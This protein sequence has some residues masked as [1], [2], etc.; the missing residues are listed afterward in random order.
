MTILNS[1]LFEAL[2]CRKRLQFPAH[3]SS[4]S[5]TTELNAIWN[6]QFMS[7]AAACDGQ[8]YTVNY[9]SRCTGTEANLLPMFQD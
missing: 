9:G 5:K 6:F 3:L 4:Q 1:T 2:Q 7:Q 8:T